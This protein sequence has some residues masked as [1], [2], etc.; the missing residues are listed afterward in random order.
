MLEILVAYGRE[1]NINDVHIDKGLAYVNMFT[2]EGPPVGA[3]TTSTRV[4]DPSSFSFKGPLGTA[5]YN[6][7]FYWSIVGGA[8]LDAALTCNV[9]GW[10]A[11]G[12]SN[13]AGGGMTNCD[14]VTGQVVGTNMVVADRWSTSQQAPSYDIPADPQ[15]S[16][17]AVDGSRVGTLTTIWWSRALNTNDA[18]D[19]PIVP[20]LMEVNFA[21]NPTTDLFAYHDKNRATTY[22]DFINGIIPMS[23]ATTAVVD[24]TWDPT[25]YP[26]RFNVIP[27]VFEF[28][29]N[30]V[31]PASGGTP[32]S[33][34]MAIR[35]ARI[36]WAALG[37][38]ASGAGL[39]TGAD[40]MMVTFDPVTGAP[41]VDDQTCIG[42][43]TPISDT[44]KGGSASFTNIAGSRNSTGMQIKW[45]R[46]LDTGD[47]VADIVLSSS[48][49]VTFIV[50]FGDSSR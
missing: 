6:C 12:L 49:L 25:A 37:P 31:I 8:T 15:G 23:G 28:Y 34:N 2:G 16:L 1:D 36:G 29:W 19:R 7:T 50:A 41:I 35:V 48:G 21:I 17:I 30:L 11:F 10:I 27:G 44:V 13:Q 22:I 9:Q 5:P 45:T 26:N 20:G 40:V 3:Q 46:L 43:S 33:V 4:V 14:V 42:Q 38:A 24:A 47:S 18:K 32:T 39:M